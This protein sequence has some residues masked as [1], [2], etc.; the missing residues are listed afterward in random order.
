M[1]I[2][3]VNERSRTL[4]PPTEQEEESAFFFVYEK[5]LYTLEKAAYKSIHQILSECKINNTTE[6]FK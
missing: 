1:F 5:Q 6:N 4:A 3:V 2:N